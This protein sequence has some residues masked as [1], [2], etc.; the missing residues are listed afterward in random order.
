MALKQL[1]TATPATF[2]GRYYCFE[3]VTM[4][5]RPL[6]QPHPPI[7]VGGRSAAALRRAA[8]LG[9]G[10]FAYFETPQSFAD[11]LQRARAYRAASD[12][13]G[14]AFAAG[15]VLY[16]CVAPTYEAA[17]Q[18]AVAYLSAEYRQP[19]AHLVD[20]YC[21]L[22]PLPQCLATIERFIAAGA[23]HLSL[24][25]TCAPPQVLAQLR[26]L[27]PALRQLAARHPQR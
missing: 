6:Q 24:I 18:Q 10:W 13:A 15:L 26:Q 3:G 17:R 22:G 25:P 1:W 9:N 23:Q 12:R 19:F 21:A 4:A 11:K 16:V 14:E 8:R 20:K 27:A 7:W 5:P 2:R